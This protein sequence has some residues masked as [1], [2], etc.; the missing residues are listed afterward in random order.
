MLDCDVY[1]TVDFG[2]GPVEVRCT[3]KG[4]HTLHMSTVTMIPETRNGV[5]HQ[6]IFKNE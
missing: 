2:K 6:N 1:F 3:K 4:A 5:E